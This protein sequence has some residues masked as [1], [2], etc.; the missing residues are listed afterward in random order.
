[1]RLAGETDRLNW[2][3]GA[4]YAD[5]DLTSHNQLIYGN[6]FRTYFNGLVQ[7]A[8]ALFPASAWP[9]NRGTQDTYDQQSKTWALF[10]N[11][12]LRITDALELTVGVRYTDE[13]KDLDTRYLN[14]HGGVGCTVLRNT[15]PFNTPPFLA[16]PAAATFFGIGCATYADPIFNNLTTAQT[17]DEN[18]WSG[19]AKLAY[20]FTDEFMAYVSFARGYKASGFNLDRERTGSS[21][22]NPGTPGGIAADTDTSFDKELV[23]SYEVGRQDAVGGEHAAAERRRVLPGLRGLSAEHVHWN[24][25][26]SHIAPAGR[27]AGRGRGHGVVHAARAT[28]PSGRRHLR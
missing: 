17:I 18:E 20:R 3:V 4:F 6:H 7:N 1:M 23:D 10:T 15:P 27:I 24:S 19:T 16:S 9:A 21:A 5:E 22:L 25:V 8:L 28:E 2:L 14:Q 13:S 12:S 26:R 11:N